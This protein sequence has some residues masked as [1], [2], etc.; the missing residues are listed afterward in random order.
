MA[1]TTA[2]TVEKQATDREIKDQVHRYYAATTED[3]LKYYQ[4]G[5][6]HHMHY[7]FDR[8]LPRGG[9][10]TEHMVRYLAALAGLKPGDQVLDAGCGVGGSSIFLAREMGC[11]CIGITLVESQAHLARGFAAASF[12]K[13]GASPAKN[14]SGGKGKHTAPPARFAVNDFHVPA[15]KPGSFDVVWAVESFDHAVDKE[16][17]VA[18]MFDLLKPGGRLIIADG[19]RAGNPEDAPQAREYS[20]FL[21]GW[22]VPHLCSPAEMETYGARAGFQLLHGEDISADVLP[23]AR[24][25]FRFGLIFIPL[26]WM[27]RKLRLTSSEKLGNAYATYYQYRTLKQGLWAYCAYCFRKPA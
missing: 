23:H 11:R 25:I 16:A 12:A 5:W 4:S 7:G 14:P 13:A 19:F 18:S 10:P 9:N 2:T 22:A 8:D 26:R 6:H 27:L 17:W 21:A 24:A 15:F 3:Y 20:S 1:E